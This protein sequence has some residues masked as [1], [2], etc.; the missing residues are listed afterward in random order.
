MDDEQLVDQYA[1]AYTEFAHSGEQAMWNSSAGDGLDDC[2]DGIGYP[3]TKIVAGWWEYHRLSRGNRVERKAL[4]VGDHAAAQRGRDAVDAAVDDGGP[5]TVALL[6]ALAAA[7]PSPADALA[8]GVG[9]L[10]DLIHQH[11]DSL[12]DD[13]MSGAASSQPFRIALASVWLERGAL[14]AETERRLAGSVSRSGG[15]RRS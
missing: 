10:E 3:V 8:V 7:A 15:Q 6:V 13:I 2:A 4:E 11:G 12:I 1:A 9:P 14:S 5:A